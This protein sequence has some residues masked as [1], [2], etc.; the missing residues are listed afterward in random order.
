MDLLPV[1]IDIEIYLILLFFGVILIE[2]NPRKP[3]SVYCYGVGAY[4]LQSYVHECRGGQ[5]PGWISFIF[6]PF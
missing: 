5:L 2:I 6:I 3:A 4:L 1:K